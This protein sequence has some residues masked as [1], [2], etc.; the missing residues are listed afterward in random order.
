MPCGVP[1]GHIGFKWK[2]WEWKERWTEKRLCEI[3]KVSGS[4]GEAAETDH[5]LQQKKDGGRVEK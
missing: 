5:H 3:A 4:D 2:L 1:R